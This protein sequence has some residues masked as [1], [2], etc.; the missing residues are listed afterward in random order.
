MVITARKKCSKVFPKMESKRGGD[1]QKFIEM[2]YFMN[3]PQEW[4]FVVGPV[5][6]VN[7]E[8]EDNNIYGNRNNRV[9]S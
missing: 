1:I 3:S 6:P 9:Y 2:V 5:L 7:Q 4:K 8:I